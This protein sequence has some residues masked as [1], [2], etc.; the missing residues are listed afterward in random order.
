MYFI[1]SSLDGAKEFLK[2]YDNSV[3][4]WFQHFKDAEKF[5]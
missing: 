2:R 4:G 1:V 5:Q 3:F